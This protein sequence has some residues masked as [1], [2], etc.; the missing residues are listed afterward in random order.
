MRE[1]ERYV[2]RGVQA[3]LAQ[4]AYSI[5]L[6]VILHVFLYIAMGE[7]S[8]RSFWRYWDIATLASLLWGGMFY[9]TGVPLWQ[10]ITVMGIAMISAPNVMHIIS[11]YIVGEGRDVAIS[12]WSG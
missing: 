11:T 1:P 12:Q 9:A 5:F 6:I 7:M 2:Q 3:V 4:A 8:F 10:I